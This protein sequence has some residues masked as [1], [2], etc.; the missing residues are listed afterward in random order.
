MAADCD[1]TGAKFETGQPVT[2]TPKDGDA[3]DAIV[4]GGHEDGVSLVNAAGERIVLEAP[5]DA[6]GKRL[7][8]KLD[9]VEIT[10]P[11]PDEAG[12]A[13]LHD[14]WAADALKKTLAAE[15]DAK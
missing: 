5:K 13:K 2:V 15:K 1:K 12:L 3:Y 9:D 6:K 14:A 7:A 8:D 10:G 11:A 4:V